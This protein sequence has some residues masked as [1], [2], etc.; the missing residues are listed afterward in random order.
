MYNS[1][2]AS[3]NSRNSHFAQAKILKS[4]LKLKTFHKYSVSL[5][6][7]NIMQPFLQMTL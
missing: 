7:E 3:V 4:R 6:G 5:L 1:S 2:C